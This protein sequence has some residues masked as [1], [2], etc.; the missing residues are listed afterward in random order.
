M[1]FVLVTLTT[2]ER[3]RDESRVADA[4]A[5]APAV[6]LVGPR[7]CGKS[8]LARVV[9]PNADRFDLED[10]RDR[11]RLAEPALALGGRRSTIVIDEAQR[12][13]GLFEVL[14]VLIDEDRTPGRFLILGSAGPT[15]I[16]MASES[17]AGRVAIVE[18]GGFRLSDV[19]TEPL[20]R[21][22]VRGGLPPSFTA[23]D[24]EQSLAWRNDYIAT[25]L[26]RDLPGLGFPVPAT[27]M[28]RFW[29]M[30]AHLHGQVWNGADV[31]RSLAVSAPTVRRYL[32]AMTDALVVRQLLPWYANT[33]KRQVRSPKVYVRD[34]GLL[35][36]LL[37]IAD[38][39]A[40]A[41]H[42]RLG[43][44][45]E[46]FVLEQL[47]ARHP[48]RDPSFWGTHAGAELD[49]RLVIDGVPIGVEVKRTD[50]P[51]MTRSVGAALETLDVARIVIVH[52]GER[53]FPL[54]ERVTAVPASLAL[55][56][57]LLGHG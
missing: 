53:A 21:L 42:P 9:V 57:G 45:W 28:R 27:T 37:G 43:A 6:V 25:F 46:G 15:L 14:R 2:I 33:A 30:V 23:A 16:G 24:A 44:S 22:W 31:A 40:L 38:G 17:L 36:A 55:T 5:R 52:A 29:T 13:P 34:T 54:A 10:P 39:T 51:T 26:E 49:L 56:A 41:R 20:D 12:A 8:T 4:L 50:R 47:L 32:D 18:L 3:S 35:H 19:G 11:A 7:Q 48:Q 1:Y